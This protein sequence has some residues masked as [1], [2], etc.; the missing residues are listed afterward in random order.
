MMNEN[1]ATFIT[2]VADEIITQLK[3]NGL[4]SKLIDNLNVREQIIQS[5]AGNRYF[6]M[7]CHAHLNDGTLN[8]RLK[9]RLVYHT[10][11]GMPMAKIKQRLDS[12]RFFKI[13]NQLG[14]TGTLLVWILASY[15][16]RLLFD[17]QISAYVIGSLKP[18]IPLI[19]ELLPPALLPYM[20]FTYFALSTALLRCLY[21]NLEYFTQWKKFNNEFNKLINQAVE[22]GAA[23][24]LNIPGI[25]W[26]DIELSPSTTFRALS[27]FHEGSMS[28]QAARAA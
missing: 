19:I 2:A 27:L 7:Q 18:L 5:L 28:N 24:T 13:C 10:I 16:A 25:R 4:A 3:L 20:N 22:C 6:I 12:L 9:Q 23:L 14:V 15:E 26:R 1:I 8:D 11:D 17:E 21:N